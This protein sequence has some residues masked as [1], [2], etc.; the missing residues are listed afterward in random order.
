MFF[1][2]YERKL[3]INESHLNVGSMLQWPLDYFRN[4]FPLILGCVLHN[5]FLQCLFPFAEE[6]TT[7]L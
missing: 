2:H 5:R 7:Y 3:Q 6:Q 1:I 4:V